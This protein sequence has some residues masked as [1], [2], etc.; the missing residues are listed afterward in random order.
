MQLI[1]LLKT[2]TYM[3]SICYVSSL[4][5][6]SVLA[7]SCGKQQRNEKEITSVFT[8]LIEA[9]NSQDTAKIRALHGGSMFWVRSDLTKDFVQNKF[10]Q[11]RWDTTFATNGELSQR[12]F[13]IWGIAD[14]T[15][16]QVSGDYRKS[17][18]GTITLG[19]SSLMNLSTQCLKD[20]SLRQTEDLREPFYCHVIKELKEL[21][22][23]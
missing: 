19:Y 20:L 7:V 3:K 8:N 9:M 1:S 17:R 10:V 15:Y 16:Y 2:P 23:E 6:L 21:H 12:T 14:T 11:L 5:L 22:R 4:A 18:E 13:T